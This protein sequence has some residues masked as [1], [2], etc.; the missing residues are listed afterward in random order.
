MNLLFTSSFVVCVALLNFSPAQADEMAL[1]EIQVLGQSPNTGAYDFVPTVSK[2]SGNELERKKQSTVGETLAREPGVSSSFYGPNASRPIIRGLDGEKIKILENGVGVIDASGTSPDH[3]VSTDPLIIDSIEIVRGPSALLY[4]SGAI[5]GVVNLRNTRIANRPLDASDLKLAGKLSSVDRGRSL[6]A[7]LRQPFGKSW[8]LE[9]DGSIRGSEDY[10]IPGFARSSYLRANDGPGAD[11]GDFNKVTNSASRFG[12]LGLGITHVDENGHYGLA[13]SGIK[14][15]YGTVA[16]KTVLIDMERFR[17]DFDSEFKSDG[18]IKAVDV[19]GAASVYRHQEIDSGE[20]GT[21]F[22]NKGGDLRVDLKHAKTGAME[23]MFGAQAQY[24]HFSALGDE[25]FLP[26]THNLSTAVFAFEEWKAGDF[27]P[28]LGIRAD[29]ASVES[30]D[31]DLTKFSAAQTKTFFTP[32]IAAGLLYSLDTDTTAGLNLTYTERA[33]NYQELFANGP[34]LATNA[35]EIGDTAMPIERSLGAELSLRRKNKENEGRFSLYAQSFS[36]FIALSKTGGTHPSPDDPAET[37]DDYRYNSVAALL[38]GAEVEYK[39]EL[40]FR[41]AE[42]KFE[43]EAQFDFVRGLDRSNHDWLPRMS[44]FRESLALN[45]RNKG[46]LGQIEAQRSEKQNLLAAN[47]LPTDA[48]TLINLGVE[49]PVSTD[50]GSF[51]LIGRVNNLFN[52]EARVATSFLKDQAP[53]P[54]RNFIL[55]LQASL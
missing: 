11:A 5:G 16:E 42:G 28:S 35:W 22:R 39:R 50:F 41:L 37:V 26:T 44:P 8:I 29:R 38:F 55:G 23:G 13:L 19:K 33:P 24:F 48:F 32:S 36:S 12:Q 52:Q 51:R 27:K 9:I 54:G 53:L 49:A 21:T 47:E 34:H 3:A 7:V 25:A 4:G 20:V 45:Y 43:L 40:P 18:F 1:P 31:P 10:E 6:G 2:I 17:L 30:V 14:N 15:D 46:W